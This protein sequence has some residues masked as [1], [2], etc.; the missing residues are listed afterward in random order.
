MS[1]PSGR[2]VILGLDTATA[3]VA[4]AASA[5]GKPVAERLLAPLP[6]ERPR[7]ATAL[8]GLVTEVVAEAGG[9]ER[10]GVIAAGL[11]P[12]SFTGLRVGISTARALAQAKR[13]EIAGVGSLAALAA[14]IE[15]PAERPR[16][17]VIDA[18]RREVFAALH[19]DDG[20]VEWEPFV[21][22]PAALAERVR[23]LPTAPLAAGDGSLRFREELEAAGAEVPPDADPVH[24]MAARHVCALAEGAPRVRPEQ[25]RPIYLRRPDA[26]VWRQRQGHDRPTGGG[27]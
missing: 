11:G 10:V 13:L 2:P 8:L 27:G 18:K 25:A 1:D 15:G 24:R 4:V 26:E 22:A 17:A 23:E 16:L 20:G 21:A 6:G 14:G 3:D 9:W 12:G 19:R 5:D 7:H